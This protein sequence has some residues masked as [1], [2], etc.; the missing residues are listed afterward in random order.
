MDAKG[1]RKSYNVNQEMTINN[2]KQWPQWF[3]VVAG[4]YTFI[5][6]FIIKW[7]VKSKSNM[8]NINLCNKI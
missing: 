1:K 4:Y 8:T 6:I 3:T 2:N 7:D 5:I